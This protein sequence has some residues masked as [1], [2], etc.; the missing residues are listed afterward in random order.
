[1]GKKGEDGASS[2]LPCCLTNATERAALHADDN[3]PNDDPWVD[4]CIEMEQALK[5]AQ[6]QGAALNAATKVLL[7]NTTRCCSH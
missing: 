6:A 5:D 1:M 7:C 4:V 3:T 2:L